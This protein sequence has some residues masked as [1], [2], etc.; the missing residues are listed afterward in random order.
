M[1]YQIAWDLKTDSGALGLMQAR[2]NDLVKAMKTVGDNRTQ[3][4]QSTAVK[5]GLQ[6]SRDAFAKDMLASKMRLDAMVQS[7]KNIEE[8]MDLLKNVRN[9]VTSSG[10]LQSKIN[11]SSNL[12]SSMTE[13]GRELENQDLKKIT[14]IRENIAVIF[15]MCAGLRHNGTSVFGKTTNVQ[16]TIEG[17]RRGNVY[18]SR[19]AATSF[20]NGNGFG[21]VMYQGN[22]RGSIIDFTNFYND[23]R[24]NLL[25]IRENIKVYQAKS[26]VTV[27]FTNAKNTIHAMLRYATKQ[28]QLFSQVNSGIR[29]KRSQ[30]QKKVDNLVAQRQNDLTKEA[31][32]GIL[33]GVQNGVA[34][35][36]TADQGTGR[37]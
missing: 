32:I 2:G 31:I 3:G 14:K 9:L 4:N 21:G 35:G 36:G 26:A 25:F 5:R 6:Q 1:R 37:I 19:G 12:W 17:A 7:E 22:G 30:E 29:F 23:L 33:D 15:N 27:R 10:G 24:Q 16:Q 28:E 8:G 11:E 20:T 18:A 34:S 13:T